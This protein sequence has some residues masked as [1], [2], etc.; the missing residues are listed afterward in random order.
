MNVYTFKM[1]EI[2]NVLH[3][4]DNKSAFSVLRENVRNWK[5]L[6]DKQLTQ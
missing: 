2:K 6:S 1:F 5:Q 4:M 3:K